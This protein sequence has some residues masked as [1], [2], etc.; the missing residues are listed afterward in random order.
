MN[1]PKV[2]EIDD[3]N[4]L[5]ATP[6]A[7]SCVGAERV[8]PERENAPAHDAITRLLHRMF[9]SSD[10][11]WQEAQPQVN[12]REGVLVLDDLTLGQGDAEKMASVTRHWSGKHGRVVQGINLISLLW[13]EGDRPIP[14]DYR[15]YEKSGDGATKNDHFCT[16]LETAKERGFAPKCVV[17][18][19]GYSSHANLKCIRTQG[20]IHIKRW[21]R[22]YIIKRSQVLKW[23]FIVGIGLPHL[24]LQSIH[25][26]VH[27]R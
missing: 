12:R 7:Y 1:P 14:L 18:D 3:I 27:F 25:R 8:Q 4:F 24:S 2:S 26:N 5:I 22:K 15:F 10:P 21:I 23:I 9:P 13:S 11:L 17:F 20:I 19:S 16:M 6:T